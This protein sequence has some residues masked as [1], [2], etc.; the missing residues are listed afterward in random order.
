MEEIFKNETKCSKS[1]YKR[2][3]KAHEKGYGL[4]EDIGT[5]IIFLFLV[6]LFFFTLSRKVLYLSLL[7]I[8]IGV[9]FVYFSVIK[10]NKEV[11]KDFKS[12]K[13]INEY[14]NTYCFYKWFFTMSS[15]EGNTRFLY[16]DIK[17]VLENNTHYYVYITHRRAFIISKKGFVKGNPDEFRKFLRRRTFF[18]YKKMLN[19]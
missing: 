10:I 19:N 12:K 1:E 14:V 3:M 9:A 16:W 18:K 13:V 11:K 17:K 6:F 15:E 4:K 5:I 8:G 2:F 7:M